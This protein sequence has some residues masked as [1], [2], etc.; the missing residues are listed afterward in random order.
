MKMT[1]EQQQVIL[2]LLKITPRSN[3]EILAFLSG[4]D[5]EEVCDETVED[6]QP[7]FFD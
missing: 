5:V 3:K 1:N 4:D 2:E 6:E 7:D